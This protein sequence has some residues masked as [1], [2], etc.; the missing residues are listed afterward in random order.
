LGDVRKIDLTCRFTSG[1]HRKTIFSAKLDKR[2]AIDVVMRTTP[3]SS[4][5]HQIV[6]LQQNTIKLCY[7]SRTI[8]GDYIL[9]TVLCTEHHAKVNVV[10]WEFRTSSESALNTLL[11][12][13]KWFRV[14]TTG[15]TILQPGSVEMDNF[16]LFSNVR[17][18]LR[19]S[20]PLS[21]QMEQ[22]Q[23]DKIY[24]ERWKSLKNK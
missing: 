15:M 10:D 21:Y 9:L 1:F 12:N 17:D 2:S 16:N 4:V 13:D 19:I 3:F 8:Y 14:L 5:F 6:N 20:V 7:A 11:T 23:L 22:S 24:L 18:D